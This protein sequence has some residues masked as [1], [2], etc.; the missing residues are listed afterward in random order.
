MFPI[1]NQDDIFKAVAKELNISEDKVK[2][3]MKNFWLG[4][5][6]YLTHPLEAGNGIWLEK[7]L[8]FYIPEWAVAKVVE[9]LKPGTFKHE[10]YSKL[11]KQLRDEKQKSKKA[12]DE[13]HDE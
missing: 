12:N 13:G 4:F 11:L 10:F 8:R 3:V 2:F 1:N 7:F 5:R 6:Y 9:N